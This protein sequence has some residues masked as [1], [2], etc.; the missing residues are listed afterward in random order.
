VDVEVHNLDMLY[1][2]RLWVLAQRNLVLLV[3]DLN[4]AGEH[5]FWDLDTQILLQ[6]REDI[7]D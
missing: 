4:L 5:E 2:L 7:F 6:S 1:K 3:L